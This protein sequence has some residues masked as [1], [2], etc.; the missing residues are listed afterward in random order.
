MS[1]TKKCRSRHILTIPR[2]LRAFF[3]LSLIVTLLGPELY[4]L[5]APVSF[6]P[7]VISFAFRKMGLWVKHCG[8]TCGIFGVGGLVG[9]LIEQSA[10]F[11]RILASVLRMWGGAQKEIYDIYEFNFLGWDTCL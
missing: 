3:I 6:L 1:K 10:F 7:F 4:L 5:G 11:G 8:V 2:L 9:G